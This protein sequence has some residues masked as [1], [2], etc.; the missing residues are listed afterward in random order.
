MAPTV[1]TMVGSPSTARH[2]SD[3]GAPRAGRSVDIVDVTASAA[4]ASA[5]QI[6]NGTRHPDDAP[7]TPNRAATA[8]P[9]LNAT[10]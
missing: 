8:S 9:M 4:S 5:A 6:Q 1:P 7:I 10:P 2:G 3:Q